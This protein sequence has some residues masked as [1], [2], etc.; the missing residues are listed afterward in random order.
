VEAGKKNEAF[1]VIEDIRAA[2]PQSEL[3]GQLDGIKS[4]VEQ[5]IQ[6]KQAAPADEPA[7]APE[8]E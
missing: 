1:Q 4:R 8:K 2:A 6:E 3:A 7:P 5:Y